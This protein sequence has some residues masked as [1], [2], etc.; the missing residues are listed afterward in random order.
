M[1]DL[2][3]RTDLETNK[4]VAIK[5]IDV[6]NAEDEVEDIVTEIQILSSMTSKHVTEYYGA[7]LHDTELWIVMELCSGGSCADLLKPGP[8]VEA[9]IAIIMREL[10]LALVYLHDDNKLHRDIKGLFCLSRLCFQS[11]TLF[12][13]PTFLCQPKVRSSWQTSVSLVSSA[14]L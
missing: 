13:P 5:I 14:A 1:T 11:L 10:L 12:Q 3:C 8:L 4:P 6:E 7:F 9:E 2:L